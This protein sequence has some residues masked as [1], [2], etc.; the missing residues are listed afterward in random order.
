M[1]TTV[2]DQAIDTP[3]SGKNIVHVFVCAL[4]CVGI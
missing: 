4:N 3:N 1:A 2:L